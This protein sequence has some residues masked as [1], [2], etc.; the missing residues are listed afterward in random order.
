VVHSGGFVGDQRR[1]ATWAFSAG[2][3]SVA[4]D[5]RGGNHA[6]IRR[7]EWVETDNGFGVRFDGDGH[8]SVPSSGTLDGSDGFDFAGQFRTEPGLD[9]DSEFDTPR[10]ILAKAARGA[11]DARS[12]YQLFLAGGRIRGVVGDGDRTAHVS[13]PRLDDGDWHT[14]RLRWDDALELQV[15]GER[16]DTNRFDGDPGNEYDLTVAATSDDH[17]RF[18]GTVRRVEFSTP[19]S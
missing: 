3:G 11:F 12:G 5:E 14:I 15:D 4:F 2:A 17:R 16:V 10:R 9:Y 7:S 6:L 18:V 13:G 19:D 1:E 8:V